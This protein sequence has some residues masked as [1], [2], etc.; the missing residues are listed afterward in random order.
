[1]TAEARTICQPGCHGT[2]VLIRALERGSAATRAAV[3]SG[4]SERRRLNPDRDRQGMMTRLAPTLRHRDLA[5]P[6]SSGLL[7]V[8][9]RDTPYLPSIDRR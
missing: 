9:P 6:R 2:P 1:M 3:C 4:D 8:P 7:P 5:R